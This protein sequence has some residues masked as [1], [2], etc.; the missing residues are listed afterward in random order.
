VLKA[1][2]ATKNDCEQNSAKRLL[3]D[4]RRE[5]PHLKLIAVQDALGA[6]A[7]NLLEFKF[8]DIRFI[9]GI[10]SDKHEDLFNLAKQSGEI[11]QHIT[12]DGKTHRYR[13][14]NNVP[15]NRTGFEI[16]FME[17][18]ETDKNGEVKY[19]SWVTD[20]QITNEN[21]YHLMRGG[22]SN[23]QLENNTFNTL[24]NQGVRREAH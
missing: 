21:A 11:Y 14:I 3:A 23:W 17:Y 12:D 20:I 18:W 22:R 6:T 16:N 5:H 24:K 9:V 2:G 19:F 4:I 7:P 8:A 10:K 1:D 13:Y 15:L